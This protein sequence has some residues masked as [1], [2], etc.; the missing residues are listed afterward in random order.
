MLTKVTKL[1]SKLPTRDDDNIADKNADKDGD[2][3]AT[4]I[5]VKSSKCIRQSIRQIHIDIFTLIKPC[6]G[7]KGVLTNEK[8][9]FFNNHGLT[10][11]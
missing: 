9:C 3:V 11:F 7:K 5:Y 8:I 4:D 10:N 1:L 2:K 6:E